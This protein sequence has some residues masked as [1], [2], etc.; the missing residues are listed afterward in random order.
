MQKRAQFFIDDV[1]WLFRDLT[2]KRPKSMFDLPYLAGLKKAY[3]LYGVKSQLNVFYRTCFWYGNDEFSLSD[4]TDAYKQEFIENS[5]WL[6]FAFHAKEEWPDYPYV[7][8]DYDLVDQNFKLVRDEIFRFAGENSFTYS[9]VPHWAPMSKE[10]VMALKDNGIKVTYATFGEKKEWDGDQNSLP[11]GHSFRLIH[12]KKL[13]TGV[14]TKVTRDNAIASALCS[15]NHV[16]E[17]EYKSKIGKFG[18]I[19]DKETGMCYTVAAE[20]VLNL[21]N[22][23]ILEDEIKKFT[24]YE[25]LTIG[26]H[27]QYYYPDYY[28]YQPDYMEK[29]LTM[30]KVLKEAGY[31]FVFAEQLCD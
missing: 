25:Y 23:D 3:D 12:N 17:E 15:Y 27:E 26:N 5:H 22:L 19:K 8:A 10:G 4:M 28:A 14:Y 30:G 21:C 29:I 20:V 11:Y 16:T 7:N 1:I 24:N 18:T 13:E 9:V 2:R 31:T 6:K